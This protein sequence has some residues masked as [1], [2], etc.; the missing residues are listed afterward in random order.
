LQ[1]GNVFPLF[2]D[3]FEEDVEGYSH[4]LMGSNPDRFTFIEPEF[5]RKSI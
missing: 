3:E 2:E 1:N 5:K 4:D